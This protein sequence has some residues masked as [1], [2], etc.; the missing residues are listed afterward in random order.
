MARPRRSARRQ[1]FNYGFRLIE[2]YSDARARV[3]IVALYLRAVAVHG[4]AAASRAAAG[5]DDEE[6]EQQQ[7]QQQTET[8]TETELDAQVQADNALLEAPDAPAP[9]PTS[10]D[11]H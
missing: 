8:E 4:F 1:Y 2:C 9:L 7:Q 10:Q 3:G 6:E 11:K 5:L